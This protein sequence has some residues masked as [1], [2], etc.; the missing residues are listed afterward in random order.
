MKMMVIPVNVQPVGNAKPQ[1]Y[2][3]PQ[4]IACIELALVANLPSMI[5]MVDETKKQTCDHYALVNGQGY[6][7]TAKSPGGEPV[8]D[9]PPKVLGAVK[10]LKGMV[11]VSS[12]CF[13]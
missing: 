5:C 12:Y 2:K 1:T 10:T 3:G 11:V 7:P 13:A 6:E 8:N 4:I 9:Q